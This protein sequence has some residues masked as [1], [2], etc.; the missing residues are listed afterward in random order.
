MSNQGLIAALPVHLRWVGVTVATLAAVGV[1]SAAA[2]DWGDRSVARCTQPTEVAA[3]VAAD[4]PEGWR[5]RAFEAAG[6]EAWLRLHRHG[7]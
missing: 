7:W 4:E 6:C 5:N 2:E 1:L 3:Q